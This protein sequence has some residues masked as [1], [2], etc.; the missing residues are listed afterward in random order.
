MVWIIFDELSQTIAFGN[1]PPGLSLPNLDRLKQESFYAT[2]AEP[3]AATTL[4]SLPSL[5]VGQKVLEAA[6]EGPR[7]L[8]L[9]LESKPGAVPWSSLPNV[10]D[11]ARDLGFNTA[12]VGW[13]HPYG[14]VPAPQPDGMLLDVGM[15]RSRD[16][17]AGAAGVFRR[18]HEE[19]HT[20]GI[21]VLAAGR[22]SAWSASGNFHPAP[23]IGEVHFSGRPRTAGGVGPGIGLAL[24]SSA[25][26][27]SSGDLR[28]EPDGTLSYRLLS[29]YQDDLR[30]GRSGTGPGCAKPSRMPGWKTALRFW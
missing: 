23:K 24:D 20:R 17:A 2:A 11:S 29:G 27:V 28:S 8:L 3:P 15:G 30:A 18:Q 9:K 13:Y 1:R 22:S 5:I 19:P 6:S 14:R 12:L 16:R 7:D 10:F 21:I 25:G 4:A 26:S